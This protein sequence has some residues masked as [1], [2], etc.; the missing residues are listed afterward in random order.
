MFLSLL[1]E[2]YSIMGIQ[3]C[4][5]VERMV[6]GERYQYDAISR[7]NR[8]ANCTCVATAKSSLDGL[9]RSLAAELAPRI[10]VNA[11]APS[12]T[13]TPLASSL[14][15]DEGRRKASAA[16]HPLKRIGSP[17]DAAAAARFLLDASGSW[18]TGQVIPVDGGM[19]SLRIFR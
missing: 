2:C 3:Q 5:P 15:S 10:R 17:A 6:V 14:L 18:I 7:A 12:V 4:E 16:Y 19:G 8:N 11:V 13:D 9:T 1:V